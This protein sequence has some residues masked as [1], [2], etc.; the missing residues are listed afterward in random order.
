MQQAKGSASAEGSAPADRR[1]SNAA[2]AYQRT[3]SELRNALEERS[4]SAAGYEMRVSEL[5][6]ALEKQSNAAAGYQSTIHELRNALEERSKEAAKTEEAI[7]DLQQDKT[8]AERW[9]FGPSCIR[10]FC[11]HGSSLMSCHGSATDV[12]CLSGQSGELGT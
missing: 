12:T 3:I 2:A 11:M 10:S 5:S 1:E 9:S 6:S 7:R 8:K 4:R